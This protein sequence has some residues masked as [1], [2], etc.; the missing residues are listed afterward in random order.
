LRAQAEPPIVTGFDPEPI[1]A[2][3]ARASGAFDRVQRQLERAVRDADLVVVALPL[4][5]LRDTFQGIAPALRAGCLV[6]DVANL[7]LPVMAWADEMLP[8]TVLFAGGHVLIDPAR[9]PSPPQQIADA[10]ADLLRGALYCF[11]TPHGSTA[12][13]VDQLTDL[14]EALGA[15]PF[16][17][18]ATEHDG[19]QAGVDG[20]PALLA[21][22]LLLATVDTPGWR[23]MRKFAGER[24]ATGTVPIGVDDE[25]YRALHHNRDNVVLRLN[26]LLAE[27]IQFRQIL[28]QG[29]LE[30]LE[31]A[32]SKAREARA[33]WV[34]DRER[35][36]W[37]T[38]SGLPM[39]AVPNSGVLARRLLFGERMLQRLRKGPD[40]P[41][42][43]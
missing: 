8:D 10:D 5:S 30:S 27:L 32:F 38:V 43:P 12:A 2:D 35:G 11:T 40:T 17:M 4:E 42:Q 3:L 16:F 18:D 26:G 6:T 19:M 28:T 20:L 13:L 31:A 39:A 9:F 25:T 34:Q 21:A 33:N 22:A 15:Q 29:D 23:E 24:F 37:G 36:L 14:A 41:E 7:K 1:K